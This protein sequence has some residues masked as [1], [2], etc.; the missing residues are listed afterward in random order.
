[1]NSTDCEF[2]K[3]FVSNSVEQKQVVLKQN[4]FKLSLSLEQLQRFCSAQLLWQV[5]NTF[6]LVA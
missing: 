5:A 4:L 2:G 3:T 6:K 1:M